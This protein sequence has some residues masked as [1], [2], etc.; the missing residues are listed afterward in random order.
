MT[1]EGLSLKAIEEMK[2]QNIV[3]NIIVYFAFL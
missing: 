3:V 1:A 2:R